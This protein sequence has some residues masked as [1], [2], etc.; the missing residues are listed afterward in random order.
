MRR[1][2]HREPLRGRELV[3]AEHGAHLVVEDFGRGARQAAEPRAAQPVE[4]V[5]DGKPE[6]GRA[7]MH[8]QRRE[9][10]DVDAGHGALGGVEDG[11]IGR[12]G[13]ARMDAALHADFGRAA[14]PGFAHA[15]RDLVVLA[16][17]VGRAAQVSP[18]LP[19]EKA[20]NRQP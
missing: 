18:S 9:R 16:E 17:I 3:R 15:A 12:A 19:L 20:Q 2:D 14:I 7:V 1:L 4:I 5:A 10:M 6:T 8:F 13:V 11:E